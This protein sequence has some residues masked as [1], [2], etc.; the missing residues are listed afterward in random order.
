MPE[1]PPL[2]LG[3]GGK[4]Y[5]HQGSDSRTHPG[6][7]AIQALIRQ[8]AESLSTAGPLAE[9]FDGTS[10]AS[11]QNG[12]DDGSKEPLAIRAIHWG[13]DPMPFPAAFCA[14]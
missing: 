9:R 14:D 13:T 4:T 10:Q 3:D 1:A 8:A 11:S 6:V 12:T 7:R 5:G 2:S